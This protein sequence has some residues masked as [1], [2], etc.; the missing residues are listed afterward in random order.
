MSVLRPFRADDLFHFNNMQVALA[1]LLTL[2][3]TRAAVTS[4]SGRRLCYDFTYY[5]NYLSSWPDLCYVQASPSGRLMGYI[6][7]NASTSGDAHGHVTALT[8][9]PEYRRLGLAR[10]LT[11]ILEYASE[12]AY[13]AYF[14]DLFVRCANTVA[15]E[16]YERMGYS[17]WR[18][19]RGYYGLG[20]AEGGGMRRMRLV[21]MR[22]PM[23][24]DLG[25]RSVRAN[26]RDMIVD[27]P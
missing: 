27:Q 13:N 1:L 6:L 11:A 20:S 26:G 2:S 21:N 4:M 24:R 23:A 25:R 14:V 19:I 12:N 9:A 22:K 17:V 5:L 16:M 15:I 7:G 8:I 3:L 18:R 10:T